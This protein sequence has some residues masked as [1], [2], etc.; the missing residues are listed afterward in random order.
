M[1]F[2]DFVFFSVYGII[3]L[4][5]VYFFYEE[6]IEHKTPLNLPSLGRIYREICM[7]KGFLGAAICISIVYAV[8]VVFNVMGP[9]LIEVVM[10]YSPVDFGHFAL[11]MG[12]G[13]FVG[14]VINRFLLSHFPVEKIFPVSIYY[15][16]VV[17]LLM[18]VTSLVFGVQ[19]IT[20]ILFTFF[21]LI[22]S[23]SA[24][25]NGSTICLSLFPK[26]AGM[27]SAAMG[28]VA[29]V[30]TA[31]VST[32]ASFLRTDT[33]IPISLFYVILMGI[34]W[35]SYRFLMKPPPKKQG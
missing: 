24:F 6:S 32:I 11:F 26:N 3:L 29:V 19:L 30:G 14:S 15:A 16:I 17:T 28:T 33:L 7:H 4:G 18:L 25:P 2:R 12:L 5:L 23:G 34:C 21:L 31:I 13:F 35:I 8:A 20:L 9:F 22:A 1:V 27:A 10:G